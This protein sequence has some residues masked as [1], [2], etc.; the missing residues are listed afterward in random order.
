M[1]DGIGGTVVVD[2][3]GCCCLVDGCGKGVGGGGSC[4]VP[5][6]KGS[7]VCL[8]GPP[9]VIFIPCPLLVVFNVFVVLLKKC[10]ARVGCVAY[11]FTSGCV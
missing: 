10:E 1:A 11:A 2:A 7:K 3:N 6:K 4:S 8:K 5:G 9:L